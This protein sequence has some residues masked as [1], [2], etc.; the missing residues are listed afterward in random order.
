MIDCIFCKIITGEIKQERLYEDDKTIAILDINPVHYKG[1]HTLVIPK[2]HYELFSDMPDI[3]AKAVMSTML[4]V[5]KALMEFGEGLNVIQN[6]KRVAGQYVPHVH[7]HLIPRF[8]N[9]GVVISE[10][11]SGKEYKSNKEMIDT[12]KKIKSLLKS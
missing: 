2:K 7:F 4:K 6:N 10:N 1:G 8:I 3:E 9:D 12:V 11:W 5:S